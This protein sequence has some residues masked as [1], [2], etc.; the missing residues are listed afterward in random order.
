VGQGSREIILKR[1]R[2]RKR[3]REEREG[4]EGNRE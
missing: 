1:K 2:E 4:R 3:R